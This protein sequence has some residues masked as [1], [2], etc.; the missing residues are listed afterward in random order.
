MSIRRAA[1]CIAAL[2]TLAACTSTP[3]SN[4]DAVPVIVPGRPGEPASTIS[5][6]QSLPNQSSKPDTADYAFMASMIVH[7]QQALDMAALVPSR[8]TNDK[9]KAV[10]SR[11]SDA[12]RPEIDAMNA[13]LRQHGSS[14]VN[15]ADHAG[16]TMPGMVTPAQLDSLRAATGADFDRL[17]LQLMIAHHQ[18]AITMAR[19][20]QTSG[21]DTRVQELADEVIAVQ[22][23]EIG[24]MQ[25][26]Q[27][28]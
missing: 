16:H 28:H 19:D 25:A 24:R 26:M 13:W 9:V 4:P 23:A 18:G 6:G 21:V 12:Q 7:H 22:S 10:A 27:G 15:P 2:L 11:I 14:T 17:F 8:S 1:C 3:A 20:V 5:P